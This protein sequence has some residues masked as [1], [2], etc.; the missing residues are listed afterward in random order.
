M[1]ARGKQR[2]ARSRLPGSLQV[3]LIT[4]AARGEDAI[5]RS[6]FVEHSDQRQIGTHRTA[7]P[8]KVH[9]QHIRRPDFRPFEKF[10]RAEEVSPPKV[11]RKHE[12]APTPTQ[13]I[14]QTGVIQGFTTHD[15]GYIADFKEAFAIR[16]G[17]H[18]GIDPQWC[19]ALNLRNCAK[20][21]EVVS[22]LLDRIQVGN[23]EGIEAP[24]VEHRTRNAHRITSFAKAR[25]ERCIAGA[26]AA[27]GMNRLTLQQVNNGNQSHGAGRMQ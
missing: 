7:Y 25:N 8:G 17:L 26:I 15:D 4:Y 9:G 10:S 11:E 6:P 20:A 21:V 12:I 22:P 16:K 2:A 14:Y 23:I 13:H 5:R 18:T 27:P 3:S 19:R 1:N 24:C